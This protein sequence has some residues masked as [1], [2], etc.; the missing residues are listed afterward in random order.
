MLR[1]CLSCWW[2]ISDQKQSRRWH[3]VSVTSLFG[4]LKKSFI[5]RT[6]E[7]LAFKTKATKCHPNIFG[8]GANRDRNM[9]FHWFS[10]TQT[11]STKFEAFSFNKDKT[12]AWHLV[13]ISKYATLS[14]ALQ[15]SQRGIWENQ[16][17]HH[18]AQDLANAAMI[19]IV[20]LYFSW[21][22]QWNTLIPKTLSC[23]LASCLYRTINKEF[24]SA[25]TKC[26]RK[27]TF[28]GSFT[29]NFDLR[30]AGF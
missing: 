19:Y 25:M 23:M 2:S 29:Y 17:V 20:S 4:R 15:K 18:K 7:F 9:I 11:F 5:I 8:G 12:S 16:F 6:V 28:R 24:M 22:N 27:M 30:P 13:G 26:L 3:Y 21:P 10:H 1:I 14:G